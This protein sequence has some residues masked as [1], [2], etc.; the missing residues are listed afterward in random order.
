MGGADRHPQRLQ[1]L[2][3]GCAQAVIRNYYGEC[4]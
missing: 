3:S 1:D 4:T 2:L